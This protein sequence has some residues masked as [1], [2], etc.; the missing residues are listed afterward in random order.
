MNWLFRPR[1]IQSEQ[2]MHVLHLF[3]PNDETPY[4]DEVTFYMKRKL[5]DDDY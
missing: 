1:S 5:R 3:H 4:E 2:T